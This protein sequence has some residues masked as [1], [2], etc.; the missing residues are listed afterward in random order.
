MGEDEK[1]GANQL[2]RPKTQPI[3]QPLKREPPAIIRMLAVQSLFAAGETDLTFIRRVAADDDWQVR[4][5]AED[6]RDA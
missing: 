4:Q 3:E 6:L 2:R 1:E 5:A